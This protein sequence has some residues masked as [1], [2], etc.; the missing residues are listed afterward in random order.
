MMTVP[1]SPNPF[2]LDQVTALYRLGKLVRASLDLDETLAVIA[3]AARELT[4]ADLSAILLLDVDE[5]L[6]LR[7]GRGAVAAA[8]GERFPASAGIAGRALRERQTILIADMLAESD[9]ARPDLDDRSGIRAYLVTPLIWAGQ[10]VGVVT[11]AATAAG[12]LGANDVALVEELAEHAAAAVAHAHAYAHEQERRSETE[13]V[14]RQLAERTEQLERLQRQLVQSEKLTA[15]GQLANGI[16]HELNTPL[17][18]IM[19]NLSVL[20]E[21]GTAVAEFSRV[22]QEA[23]TRLRQHEAPAKVADAIQM[24]AETANLDYILEDLPQLTAESM[25]GADRIAKIVR[26]VATFARRGSDSLAPVSAEEAIEAA[27]TL[28]WSELKQRGQVVRNF[29]GV[30]LVTGQLSELAQVFVHLLLNSSQALPEQHGVI[31]LTTACDGRNVSV[32]V[33]DNGAG[34][35]ADHLSR[36]FDPFFSTREPA[37]ATGLGLSVCHGILARF[38]GTIAIES[39]L[40]R[41]TSVT[42]RLPVADAQLEA[43]A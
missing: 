23:I 2:N 17:G 20:L 30:P 16:A 35:A 29:A 18:V 39:D 1:M 40:G 22:G 8:V 41:G 33:N 21:Y 26:S 19:S 25:T 4:G 12:A 7:V 28:A 13:A 3:D 31:T 14:N 5:S 32:V 15:I 34:I 10:A 9:R 6:V 38:G 43:A 24:A 36:V 37:V 27:I 11:T 42:V